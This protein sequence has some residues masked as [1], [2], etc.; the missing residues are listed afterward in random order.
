MSGRKEDDC[1]EWADMGP[2]EQKTGCAVVESDGPC[3]KSFEI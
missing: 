1:V 2:K 3:I